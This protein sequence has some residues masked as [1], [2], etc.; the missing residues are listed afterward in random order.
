LE[1][2]EGP[3]S[4]VRALRGGYKWRIGDPFMLLLAGYLPNYESKVVVFAPVP[5]VPVEHRTFPWSPE[6]K[7][8]V[9][10]TLPVP[11]AQTAIPPT[12]VIAPPAQVTIP[13]TEVIAPPA[14]VTPPVTKRRHS[15]N[16]AK[17]RIAMPETCWVPGCQGGHMRFGRSGTAAGFCAQH[18]RRLPRLLRIELLLAR[19]RRARFD[20]F[21]AQAFVALGLPAPAP[22]TKLAEPSERR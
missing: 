11:P 12:E 4:G 13:P 17:R 16:G 14:Q 3:G 21:L 10:K 18:W 7:P 22:E 20:Y 8:K 19:V 1:A 5:V 15:K 9:V 2:A 6:L